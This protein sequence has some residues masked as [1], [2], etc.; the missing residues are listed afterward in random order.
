MQTQDTHS[1]HQHP[2][3]DQDM[4]LIDLNA[5]TARTT[6]CKAVIWERVKEG[7]FPAPVPIGTLRRDGRHSRVAWVEAEVI[8]WI[9]AQVRRA[10]AGCSEAASGRGPHGATATA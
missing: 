6:L 8:D 9:R 4:R 2:A 1:Q 5:V 10:R 3:Q 7:D